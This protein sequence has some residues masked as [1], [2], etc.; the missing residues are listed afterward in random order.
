ML[1]AIGASMHDTLVVSLHAESLAASGR[2]V[3]GLEQMRRGLVRAADEKTYASWLH[4]IAAELKLHAIGPADSA[5]E[6]DLQQAIAIARGQG[7]KLL[8]LG[9][10]SVLAR[11]WGEQGRRV[12]ARDLLAPV[13][14]WFTEGFDA[15]HLVAAKN[16]LDA[17]A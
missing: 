2:Y 5:V 17:L 3:E 1:E 6:A 13:F 11:L 9:A 14:G 16:L 7:A 10:V 8:E 12:E 4:R 15:A